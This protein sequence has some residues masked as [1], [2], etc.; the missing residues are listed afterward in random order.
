MPRL[1]APA[2]GPT[3]PAGRLAAPRRPR[4]SPRRCGLA[5][6]P[7]PWGCPSRAPTAGI[8]PGGAAARPSWPARGPTGVR[9][10]PCDAD[11]QRVERALLEGASAHGLTGELWTLARIAQLIQRLTWGA[12]PPWAPVAVLHQ[13]LGWALQRPV[14]R[15]LERRASLL[16]NVRR[17]WAPR[18][19]PRALRHPFNWQRVSMAAL[20]YGV[21]GGGA[22]LCF[23]VQAPTTPPASSRSSASCGCSWA[24]EGHAAVGRAARSPQPRDGSVPGLCSG[25]GWWW[26]GCRLRAE[27]NPVEQAWANLKGKELANVAAEGSAGSSLRRGKGSSVARRRP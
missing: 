17:T 20:C 12:L 27:R 9:P 26:N 4:C 15:A 6:S 14:R 5:R 3:A 23:H 25:T 24:G 7:A 10:R 18:G 16:P 8:P 2:P 21:G 19:R 1:P 11:L 22:S 13:R